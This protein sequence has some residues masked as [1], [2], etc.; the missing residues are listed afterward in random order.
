[1]PIGHRLN[2]MAYLSIVSDMSMTMLQSSS[3]FKWV[4]W[5]WQ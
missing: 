4:S 3:H 1:M 5:T 2:T